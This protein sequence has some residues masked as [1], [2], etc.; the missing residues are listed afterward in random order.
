MF[1]LNAAEEAEA[2]A[3]VEGALHKIRETVGIKGKEE[4]DELEEDDVSVKSKDF[5]EVKDIYSFALIITGACLV[6]FIAF[7]LICNKANFKLLKTCF[8]GMANQPILS[9]TSTK[10]HITLRKS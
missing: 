8:V 5:E 6:S 1:V 10:G 4:M 7:V 9:I 2:K 3:E